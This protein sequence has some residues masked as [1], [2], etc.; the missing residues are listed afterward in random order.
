MNLM[1]V[2]KN[3]LF[4]QIKDYYLCIITIAIST[5]VIFNSINDSQLGAGLVYI[6]KTSATQ[7]MAALDISPMMAWLLTIF[8][9]FAMSCYV[10][11]YLATT[12][13]KE[14]GVLGISG[15]SIIQTGTYAG[16]Q[17]IIIEV[18]GS[19]IGLVLGVILSPILNL[20]MSN[21]FNMDKDIWNI[22]FQCMW[23]TI[24]IIII[25]IIF[26]I[27][28]A[29]GFAYRNSI[30]DLLDYD[31]KNFVDDTRLIKIPTKIYW[32]T[33]FISIVILFLV[34]KEAETSIL[35]IIA[36]ITCVNAS[37]IIKQWIPKFMDKQRK[38]GASY[39]K[40][41]MIWVGNVIKLITRT[42]PLLI[43]MMIGIVVFQVPLLMS[44]EVPN[45]ELF[46]IDFKSFSCL[47]MLSFTLLFKIVTEINERRKGYKQINILGYSKKQIKNTIRCEVMVYFS[48]FTITSMLPLLT[49][50]IAKISQASLSAMY[51]LKILLFPLLLIIGLGFITY[52]L[53]KTA[54]FKSL[55]EC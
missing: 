44:N 47:V 37:A 30:S 19:V 49:I 48:I 50:G 31:K 28:V 32:I 21:I 12:K 9:A 41:K 27:M 6:K 25:Q 35:S 43:T 46:S 42:G 26:S 22:S 1:R 13:V 33:Y 20:I 54:V 51:V 53:Y 40:E 39:V 8:V 10:A 24:L 5:A 52:I 34:G 3:N 7:S 18:I 2:A 4:S 29:A 45:A 55:E 11:Y 17:N 38:S 36:L 23:L 15:A 16:L 14:L